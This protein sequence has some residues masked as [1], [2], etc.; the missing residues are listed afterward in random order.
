MADPLSI[1]SFGFSGNGAQAEV[2]AE[3][4]NEAIYEPC[5]TSTTIDGCSNDFL[6]QGGVTLDEDDCC[7]GSAAGIEARHKG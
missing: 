1:L 4:T 6:T 7:A 5:L 2:D 3:G